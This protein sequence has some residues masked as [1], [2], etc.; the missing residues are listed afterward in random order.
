MRFTN[1]LS[2]IPLLEPGIGDEIVE[3]REERIVFEQ[4]R[5]VAARDRLLSPPLVVDAPA[6][7][8]ANHPARSRPALLSNSHRATRSVGLDQEW[9]GHV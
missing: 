5:V 1:P 6:V 2:P 8:N 4:H 3:D 9:D 7:L